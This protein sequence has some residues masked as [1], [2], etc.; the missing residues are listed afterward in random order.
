MIQDA[1]RTLAEGKSL[2]YDMAKA[3]MGQIM[4]GQAPEGQIGAVLGMLRMKGET[5]DEI[6]GCAAAMREACAPVVP[7]QPVFEIVGTGG[8]GAN[9]FN[10][11][12]TTMFVVA[13]GGVAVAKHGN[14]SASGRCG[15][16]DCLEALGTVLNLDSHANEK[17]LAETGMCFMFAPVYHSS[18]KYAA[19]VR[20]SLGIPTVFNIL[21][22]LANPAV[23]TTQLMGVF[24]QSLVKPLAQVLANL[25]VKRGAVVYGMDGLDE[26]TACDK[27]YVCEIEEGKLTE[28]YLD[29]ADYGLPYATH[30]ALTGG[31]AQENA[32]ITKS[33]LSGEGGP[34]RQAILLNSAMSFHLTKPD[35]SI[36]D[37]LKLAA[38]LIDDGSALAQMERF[39]AFSKEVSYDS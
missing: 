28:Y 21:G 24:K 14:R 4:S 31:D 15:A 30:D 7:K 27:T 38:K 11:S 3:M 1:I 35:T 37:G 6:T 26:I 18:M 25:G 33:V 23:A 16:A 17:M 9:T 22:P 19:P 20:K 32:A 12:T 8:D 10:I 34:R 13:A 36:A 5:I 39:V 29:P 2:S